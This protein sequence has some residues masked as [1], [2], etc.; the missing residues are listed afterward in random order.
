MCVFGLTRPDKHCNKICDPVSLAW[1][2]PQKSAR[3]HSAT[4]QMRISDR[5]L[6]RL[7]FRQGSLTCCKYTLA[8]CGSDQTKSWTAEAPAACVVAA[9]VQLTCWQH[10]RPMNSTTD[11]HVQCLT[12]QM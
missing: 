5:L 6:Q 4:V 7:S 12:L 10:I 1:Y 9:L 3:D 2:P 8:V 11:P